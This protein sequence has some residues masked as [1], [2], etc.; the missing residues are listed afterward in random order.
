ML[1]AVKVRKDV[2]FGGFDIS[3]SKQK[4]TLNVT[5]RRRQWYFNGKIPY[6]RATSIFTE[7]NVE[8]FHYT[9]SYRTDRQTERKVENKNASLQ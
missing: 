5:Q 7:I 1:K 3:F 8:H 6:R 9:V 4:M 2:Q